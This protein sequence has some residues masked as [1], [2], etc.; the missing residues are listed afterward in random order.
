M[1]LNEKMKQGMTTKNTQKF[2]AKVQWTIS[3]YYN[4]TTVSMSFRLHKKHTSKCMETI[5]STEFSKFKG[6]LVV[7]LSSTSKMRE[8]WYSF[9]YSLIHK[10]LNTLVFWFFFLL[11]SFM[12]YEK[13]GQKWFELC[14]SVI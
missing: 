5:A 4:H 7:F 12:F 10:H 3:I 9:F 2:M 11:D 8:L 14:V 1:T 13:I 6:H